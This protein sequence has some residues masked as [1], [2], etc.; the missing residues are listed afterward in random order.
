MFSVIDAEITYLSEEGRNRLYSNLWA[1]KP[2]S[3]DLSQLIRSSELNFVS[4]LEFYH[5]Q[6]VFPHLSWLSPRYLRILS[7]TFPIVL[8][9]SP[10]DVPLAKIDGDC[11]T[12]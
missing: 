2:I 1:D 4:F 6:P 12:L 8:T 3:L 10:P 7:E 5:G 9:L 11:L